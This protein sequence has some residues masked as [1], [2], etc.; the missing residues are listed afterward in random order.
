MRKGDAEG[1]TPPASPVSPMQSPKSDD[2]KGGMISAKDLKQAISRE[3]KQ[4]LTDI[5]PKIVGDAS[6]ESCNEIKQVIADTMFGDFPPFDPNISH[7]QSKKIANKANK[8]K[9]GEGSTAE[10]DNQAPS[11]ANVMGQVVEQALDQRKKEDQRQDAI[12]CNLVLFGVP[13]IKDSDYQKRKQNDTEKVEALLN[14]LEADDKPTNTFRIGKWKEFQE[15]GTT[16]ARPRPL[17]ATFTNAAAIE[18]IMSKCKK[19]RDVDEENEMAG[20]N[21]CYDSTKEQRE[22]RKSM[23]TAA[24][25]KSTNCP[26]FDYKVRGPPWFLRVEKFPKK[27]E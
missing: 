19:L 11:I 23:V 27:K 7:S 20:Y 12:K 1:F 4:T 21:V 13:E 16:P 9:N 25:E 26:N 10:T 24:K 17:K 18:K 14:F 8:P 22:T 5:A 2:G 15:D 6:K 3:I